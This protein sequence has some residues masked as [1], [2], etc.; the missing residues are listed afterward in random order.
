MSTNLGTF[1][2]E[3]Q[4]VLTTVWPEITMPG[5]VYSNFNTSVQM[6]QRNIIEMA[7]NAATPGPY[8][9]LVIGRQV[10][11][12]DWTMDGAF[13]R[14]PVQVFYVAK[15]SA[16]VS[17]HSIHAKLQSLTDYLNS[18]TFSTFQV[19]EQF[20]IDTS[21]TSPANAQVW[22]NTQVKLLG[23]YLFPGAGLLV[24]FSS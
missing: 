17:Q 20:S 2:D 11:D 5:V 9:V 21:E 6:A 3:F 15:E 22:V 1:Q 14:L 18:H 13:Y 8:V 16:T 10:L 7:T 19:I 23:G 24:S 12:P 4:T